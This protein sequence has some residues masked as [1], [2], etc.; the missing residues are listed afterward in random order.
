MTTHIEEIKELLTR[1]HN[2]P[3]L[4]SL[5]ATGEFEQANK[6]ALVMLVDKLMSIYYDKYNFSKAESMNKYLQP[7]LP[8][9]EKLGIKLPVH[10]ISGEKF[11]D[12]V[13]NWTGDNVPYVEEN[14]QSPGEDYFN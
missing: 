12:Y 11:I 8:N 3:N 4:T 5:I 1:S 6:A 2:N 7:I 9:M 10:V 14:K 13:N